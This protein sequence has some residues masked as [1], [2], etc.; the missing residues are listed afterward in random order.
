[1]AERSYGQFCGL[2]RA[3]DVV[4][5]RWAL[6]LVRDLLVA[7]KRFTDLRR[8]LPKIPSNILSTRLRELEDA[9]VVQRRV[10]PRPESGVVYE[11]T[12]YGQELEEI[13][14]RLGTWGAARLGEPRPGEVLTPDAMVI[15][16][17]AMFRP[18]GAAGLRADF[19]FELGP[20]VFHGRVDDGVL[21][22]GAGPLPAPDL[23][24][25]GG[26]EVRA[27]FAGEL[28]AREAIEAGLV[29]LGGTATDPA[30][31][32]QAFTEAFRLGDGAPAAA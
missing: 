7:P 23:I 19:Q 2:A 26:P 25:S 14:L 29:R 16:L 13:V 21:Q 11:L 18:A 31:L 3:L 30:A 5:E 24:V 20:T 12:A 15:A 4:G 27:L 28:T 6:L 1:M 8:G 32:L 22:A 10:L 9:G 17:R